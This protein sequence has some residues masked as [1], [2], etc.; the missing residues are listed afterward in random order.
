[1]YLSH[2]IKYT[3]KL[4]AT[5]FSV[6]AWVIP[7]TFIFLFLG[8][9][10]VSAQMKWD[11]KLAHK[12]LDSTITLRKPTIPIKA[13]LL[14]AAFPGAGQFYNRQYYKLHLV[15][16][17]FGAMIYVVDFNSRQFKRFD[18]AYRARLAGEDTPEF[19]AQIPDE[20]LANRREEARKNKELAYFGIGIVYLLNVAD[21]FVSAHLSSFNIEDDLLTGRLKLGDTM[22]FTNQ[23]FPAI[24]ISLTF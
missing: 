20:L 14:S 10:E 17:A 19:P 4:K 16:G 9:T 7:I 13:T 3:Q 24:G 2:P 23:P 15:Y 18:E 1:M 8:V 6:R 11:E 5:T 21:A 12:L 22:E